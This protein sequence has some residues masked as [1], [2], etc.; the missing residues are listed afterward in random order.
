MRGTREAE[1]SEEAAAEVEA[2]AGAE[3]EEAAES[4]RSGRVSVGRILP[5]GG[6]AWGALEQVVRVAVKITGG[7]TVGAS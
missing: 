7:V 4:A 3:M 6:S 5:G 2:A 1:S